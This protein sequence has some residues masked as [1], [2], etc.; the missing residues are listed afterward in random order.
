MQPPWEAGPGSPHHPH[1]APVRRPASAS[2][3]YLAEPIP[4]VYKVDPAEVF[5]PCEHGEEP[6]IGVVELQTTAEDDIFKPQDGG[7]GP[8]GPVLKPT[9]LVTGCPHFPQQMGP[10]H[11][12]HCWIPCRGPRG[13]GLRGFLGR[14]LP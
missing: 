13:R 2:C 4:L 11:L 14:T 8:Q 7:E 5:D 9:C 3:P 12:V 1:L 10:H 6:G